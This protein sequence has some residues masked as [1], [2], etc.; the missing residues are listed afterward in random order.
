MKFIK[1]KNLQAD[2]ELLYVPQ[3]HWVY[4]IRHIILFLPF[5]LVLLILWNMAGSASSLAW[6]SEFGSTFFIRSVV[7]NVFLVALLVVLLVFVCRIF[8]YLSTEYGVTNKRLIAK[9]GVFRIV[10]AEIPFDRIESLYCVQGILGKISRYAT[11]YISGIGGTKPSFYMVH[12]PYAL[13]RKIVEIIE[14]NK[15]ITV[16]YD[17]PLKIESLEEPKKEPKT[18]PIYRY[19][20]F[21]RV[22][23]DNKGLN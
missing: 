13:R 11:I 5:F 14:K 22:M 1:K 15:A 18:E 10:V 21:V 9:K 2:E 23:S 6:L 20:T 7:R 3:L 12:R 17:D 4:T 8:L 16:M 19:G